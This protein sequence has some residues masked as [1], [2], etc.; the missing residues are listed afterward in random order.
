MLFLFASLSICSL[1]SFNNDQGCF[2]CRLCSS[3]IFK[4]HNIFTLKVETENYHKYQMTLLHFFFTI[5][6]SFLIKLSFLQAS[7]ELEEVCMHA[8]RV[9]SRALLCTEDNQLLFFFSF[10]FVYVWEK[11]LSFWTLYFTFYILHFRWIQVTEDEKLGRMQ[12]LQ[13]ENIGSCISM[14]AKSCFM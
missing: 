12:N 3:F 9:H 13:I 2:S 10:Q 5:C 4:A 14:T 8:T 11:Y 7:N 1:R 6:C